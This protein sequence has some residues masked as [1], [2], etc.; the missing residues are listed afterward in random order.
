MSVRRSLTTYLK[1]AAVASVASFLGVLA[2]LATWQFV[3]E[4][5]QS[6]AKAEAER[7]AIAEKRSPAGRQREAIKRF[8]Y[9]PTA[10][11][12]RNEHESTSKSNYWCGEVNGR[13][14]MGAMVGFRRYVVELQSEFEL[15]EFDEAHVDPQNSEQTSESVRFAAYWNGYCQ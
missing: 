14:R 5:R 15:A 4:H 13:N 8:L 11:V 1:L 2:A 10:A 7:L 12:F 3:V 6:S 9:D